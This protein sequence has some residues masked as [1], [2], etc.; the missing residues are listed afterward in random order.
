MLPSLA[1]V[2]PQMRLERSGAWLHPS[3]PTGELL[4]PVLP[5]LATLLHQVFNHGPDL[6][7]PT[8]CLT[9]FRQNHVDYFYYESAYINSQS[10]S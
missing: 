9:A 8:Q 10:F 3:S 4:A 1:A 2:S 5:G 6:T 7:V